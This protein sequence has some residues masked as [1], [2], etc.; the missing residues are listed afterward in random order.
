LGG[1]VVWTLIVAGMAQY[2]RRDPLM[3]GMAFASIMGVLALMIHS[4]VDF[5]LQIPA[6]A[7]MFMV[8]LALGWIARHCERRKTTSS[9][10]PQ[11]NSG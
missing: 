7:M 3:R 2:Q 10:A 5:N 11:G 6:N 4:S 9:T 8:M 1:L